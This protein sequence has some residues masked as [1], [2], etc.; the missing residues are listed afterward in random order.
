MTQQEMQSK[1]KGRMEEYL[2]ND[3]K[4]DHSKI[5]F[6]AKDVAFFKEKDVYVCE[7]TVHMKNQPGQK[8]I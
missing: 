2:N 4:K 6:E 1:L 8:K 7:F 5:A 3:P